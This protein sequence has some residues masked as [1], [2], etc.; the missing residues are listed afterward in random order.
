MN[1]N[2]FPNR[3][4]VACFEVRH[5]SCA[6]DCPQATQMLL[7]IRVA[8][9]LSFTPFSPSRPLPNPLTHCPWV[10]SPASPATPTPCAHKAHLAHKHTHRASPRPAARPRGC[11]Q[12]RWPPTHALGPNRAS[13]R[14]YP[15]RDWAAVVATRPRVPDRMETAARAPWGSVPPHL[16]RLWEGV[17]VFLVGMAWGMLGTCRCRMGGG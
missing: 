15:A 5:C 17:R 7:E 10:F 3:A 16:V 12:P 13:R 4:S 8:R 1:H 14:R 2:I 11:T 9:S 6:V